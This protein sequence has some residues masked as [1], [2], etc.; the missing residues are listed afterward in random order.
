MLS[1]SI[2]NCVCIIF[3]TPVEYEVFSAIAWH[4][5]RISN[6]PAFSD[7]GFVLG[8]FEALIPEHIIS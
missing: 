8:A 7:S 6:I 4:T 5:E 1:I 2:N 3:R